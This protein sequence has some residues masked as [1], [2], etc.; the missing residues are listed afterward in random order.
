MFEGLNFIFDDEVR[1]LNEIIMNGVPT[2]PVAVFNLNGIMLHKNLSMFQTLP[3]DKN[4]A[5]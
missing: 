4:T 3:S 5:R 2:K 1:C